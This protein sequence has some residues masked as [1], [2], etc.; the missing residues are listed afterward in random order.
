MLLTI[1]AGQ[2][3]FYMA[4]YRLKHAFISNY[5]HTIFVMQGFKA[6]GDPCIYFSR[7]ILMSDV[8]S[9]DPKRP[10]ISMRL[11]LL[12][13]I[14]K[15]CAKNPADWRLSDKITEEEWV[16]D[17]SGPP[18]LV[19]TPLDLSKERGKPDELVAKTATL[20]LGNPSKAPP[21]SL[22][23]GMRPSGPETRS[24]TLARTLGTNIQGPTPTTSHVSHARESGF[25]DPQPGS[26]R[27]D[28]G[29][30]L[31]ASTQTGRRNNVTRKDD[32][33]EQRAVSDRSRPTGRRGS[34]RGSRRGTGG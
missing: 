32:N 19:G 12:F 17:K 28:I 6:S 22:L 30:G 9:G 4:K 16:E 13:M 5:D 10:S 20:T 25:Q 21:S 15:S 29:Y 27:Q 2:V 1:F 34:S 23:A 31:S 3:V 11:A 24:R 33:A 18:G 7:A 26:Q 8:A 14:A